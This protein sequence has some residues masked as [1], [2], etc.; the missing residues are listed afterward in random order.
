MSR[1][2]AT[3][4][5]KHGDLLWAGPALRALAAFYQ[6]PIDLMLSEKYSSLEPLLS[7]QPYLDE[8]LINHDW[9]V[10]EEAPLEPREAP[11]DGYE[12]EWERLF[13]LGYRGWPRQSLPL[14]TWDCAR[15]LLEHHH[16]LYTGKGIS[17]ADPWISLPV[18]PEEEPSSVLVGFSDEWLELKMGLLG[19]A[20]ARFPEMKFRLVSGPG[21]RQ[22]EWL[23]AFPSNVVPYECGWA[24]AARL[25]ARSSLFFGC[26]SAMWVLANAMGK[27]TCIVEPSEM[28]HNEVFWSASP[29]NRLL[30][31]ASQGDKF[32]ARRVIS[33]LEEVIN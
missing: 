20:A 2:L 32:D 18:L 24:Y 33:L 19:C 14:E 10:R 15:V 17:L 8:V 26:C 22:R 5:G 9:A 1:I 25:M 23:G 28:R 12:G 4:P 29:R 31:G 16:G 27:R 11:L 7:L 30:R 6:E 13:H 3:F 21:S